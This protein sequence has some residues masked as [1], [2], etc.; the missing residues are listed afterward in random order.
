[1]LIVKLF[2]FCANQVLQPSQMLF[3]LLASKPVHLV[4]ILSVS[5]IDLALSGLAL[6]N[7]LATWWS[8]T[9]THAFL[10]ACMAFDCASTRPI[11]TR[12]LR[13]IPVRVTAWAIAIV[14]K[15]RFALSIARKHFSGMQA[16]QVTSIP[17]FCHFYQFR[18]IIC[19]IKHVLKGHC[20]CFLKRHV[21][22][23]SRFSSNLVFCL[24]I[25]L[26]DL[27]HF[28]ITNYT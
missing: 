21:L 10:S 6:R 13:P 22:Y 14:D 11:R 7:D 24:V 5:L 19:Q 2:W 20:L 27:L 3:G 26:L 28:Q 16:I 23:Q 8:R 1:M 25:F 18:L 4:D 9:S 15:K 17:L 12:T